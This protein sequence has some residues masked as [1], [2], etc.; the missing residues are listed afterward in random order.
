M[1]CGASS[2]DTIPTSGGSA[3]AA[4]A[5]T[6]R[7]EAS[8]IAAEPFEPQ[9][10]LS[11][12]AILPA[13]ASEPLQRAVPERMMKVLEMRRAWAKN[14]AALRAWLDLTPEEALEPEMEIVDPHHHA[15]DMRELQGFNLFGLFKQ[16]Y[17]MSDELMDDMVGGG[18][19]VTHSVYAE[20]HAF[21]SA[22]APEALMAPLGEVM[23]MQG[24]AAQFASGK[25]GELRAVAGI[26]GTADLAKYGA[27]A[28]PLLLACKAA[29]PNY[30]GIRVNAQHSSDPAIKFGVS[31]PGLYLEPK[32]RE[33]FALLGKH[34]LSFDAFLYSHQLGDLHD[35]ATS[36]PDTTIILNHN[37]CPAGALDRADAGKADGILQ[38][39][40]VEMERLAKDCPNVFV[41]VG[42]FG[43][44]QLGHGFDARDKPPTSGEVCEAFG[45]MYLWTIEKFG[46]DRC[47]F[48]G[49]FPVDKCSMS[50]TVLWNAYKRMVPSL[51]D[52]EAA[53]G[54]GFSD[55][56]R[57]LL[58]RGT[59]KRVYGL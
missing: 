38:G 19:N 43:M 44:P 22:D 6:T 15:W 16:Q 58:F 25:Y 50:Y 54:T 23:A 30:R 8:A 41:K 31:R 20:A 39:W 29:A 18:H 1:G 2:H 51:Q 36:F 45:A 27:D 32:F 11:Q 34:G 48:E 52:A 35:L 17:Y 13:A 57:A 26:I 56:D 40:R 37:G 12:A 59:A 24:I 55:A 10:A 3:A 47:M 4:P 7:E 49:N 21:H 14:D 9:K 53:G 28:E 46:C 5:E 33:G 42:G